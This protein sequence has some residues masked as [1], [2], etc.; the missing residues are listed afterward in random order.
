MTIGY[1]QVSGISDVAGEATGYRRR[2]PALYHLSES[3]RERRSV[4][5]ADS[6]SC[7]PR[8]S[9]CGFVSTSK[10]NSI[11]I[12]VFLAFLRLVDVN[13]AWLG[14]FVRSGIQERKGFCGGI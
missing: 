11:G 7:I 2:R 4:R 12:C 10:S 13:A 9:H 3:E 6:C 8:S 5:E 1:R 14:D